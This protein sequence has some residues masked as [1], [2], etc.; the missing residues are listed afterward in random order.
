[1]LQ[2]I[3]FIE[4]ESTIVSTR[5]CREEIRRSYC[6]IS[7]ECGKLRRRK[8]L[9]INRCDSRNAMWMFLM[10]PDCTLKS[11]KMVNFTLNIFYYTEREKK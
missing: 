1:M 2:I 7:S 6:L 5:E 10:S 11:G 4:L 9:V 3:K 8:S